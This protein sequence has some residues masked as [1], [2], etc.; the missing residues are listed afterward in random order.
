VGSEEEARDKMWTLIKVKERNR[1]RALLRM[2][3]INFKIAR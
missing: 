1:A 2:I 3:G